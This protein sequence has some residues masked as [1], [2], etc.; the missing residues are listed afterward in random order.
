MIRSSPSPPAANPTGAPVTF[1]SFRIGQFEIFDP[2]KATEFIIVDI[3]VREP[4]PRSL[5]VGDVYKRLDQLRRFCLK[6]LADLLI[7][8]VSGVS[9]SATSLRVISSGS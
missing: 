9:S 4:K 6:E 1:Q 2:E 8:W 7:V 5:I 3:V